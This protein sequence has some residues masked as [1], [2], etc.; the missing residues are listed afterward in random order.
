MHGACL[1][2]TQTVNT[3]LFA[4]LPGQQPDNIVADGLASCR[5][6]H[7]PL[8]TIV[9]KFILA[10]VICAST[11]PAFTQTLYGGSRANS[12]YGSGNSMYG[13]DETVNGYT[14]SNG[15]YVQPYHR[16][17]PDSNPYNNYSTQGN[18]NPYTG[19]IGH[20]NPGF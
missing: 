13:N 9:K 2:S 17:A 16:T 19:Q 6:R 18:V 11:A 1:S 8:E 3:L 12:L 15:T 5:R 4:R 14:R 20:K 10:A 7:L